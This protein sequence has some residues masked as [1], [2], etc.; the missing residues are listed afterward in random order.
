MH[1]FILAV[2]ALGVISLSSVLISPTSNIVSFFVPPA[3]SDPIAS[4][5]VLEYEVQGNK[6][7]YTYV[8]EKLPEKLNPHE[9]VQL[10]TESSYT[11]DEGPLA[12]ST[13]SNGRNLKAIVYS[14]RSFVKY[15]GQWYYREGAETTKAIFDAARRQSP[16]S[17]LFSTQVAYAAQFSSLSDDGNIGA[18]DFSGSWSGAHDA[19]TAINVSTTTANDVQP[20][21]GY[22]SGKA[23]SMSI[24]RAFV[25]FDTSSIP[26]NANISAASVNLMATGSPVSIDNFNDGLD[27]VTIVQ[28]SNPYAGPLTSD[29]ATCG[30]ATN[31]TEGI[32]TSER[33]DITNITT[34][35]TIT[36]NLNSTGIGWIKKSGQTS[37]CGGSTPG[38]STGLS[39]FGVREGHDTTNTTIGTGGGT[40]VV[41][42]CSVDAIGTACDPYLSV[43]YSTFAPWQFFDY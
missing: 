17:Y 12:S 11:I 22:F 2:V 40:N 6:V 15:A 35:T 31:P 3:V 25:P 7:L 16:L 27:Y 10:R 43:S 29:F 32:N 33:K 19:T 23:T 30:A 38:R 24:Q 1:T 8:G 28:T 21:V 34:S 9:V 37:N 36:F 14:G 4:R 20:L 26:A 13:Q 39:C 18:Q 5:H 42:F 41:Y